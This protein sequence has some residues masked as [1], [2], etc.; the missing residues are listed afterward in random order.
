[1]TRSEAAIQKSELVLLT[2]G[3]ADAPLHVMLSLKGTLPTP[4]YHLR[5]RLSEPDKDNRIQVEVYSLYNPDEICIQVIQQF[6]TFIP[7]GS[8]PAGTYTVWL[9]GNKV[10]DF[11]Q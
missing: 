11:T 5:A 3:L 8:Y 4:C 6:D 2:D 1:M 9:N 7:L 10:G